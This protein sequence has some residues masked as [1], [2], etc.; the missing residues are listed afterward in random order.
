MDAIDPDYAAFRVEMATGATA[1]HRPVCRYDVRDV[2]DWQPQPL[3]DGHPGWE[4]PGA[5]GLCD[6]SLRSSAFELAVTGDDRAEL[7]DR[8]CAG[9]AGRLGA[10]AAA[11]PAGIEPRPRPDHEQRDAR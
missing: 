10:R 5:G 7:R 4:F 6:F 9:C 3:S 8:W 2:R 11:H 1:R